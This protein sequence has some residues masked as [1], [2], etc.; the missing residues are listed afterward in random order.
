MLSALV[1]TVVFVLPLGLDVLSVST[2]LGTLGLIGRARWRVSQVLAGCQVGAMLVGLLLGAVLA[3]AIGKPAGYVG[4][5]VFIVLGGY[6]LLNQDTSEV[7]RVC[8]RMS[9]DVFGLIGSAS[10][11]ALTSLRPGS[12][13]GWPRFP[14]PLAASPSPSR[15]WLLLSSGYLWG[16]GSVHDSARQRGG[17]PPLASFLSVSTS[18]S[19]NLAAERQTEYQP[20]AVLVPANVVVLDIAAVARGTTMPCR[21]R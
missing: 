17:L 15:V 10:R 9:E 11:S 4:A 19:S 12:V 14:L 18:S 3:E 7:E 13:S 2:A 5:G 6:L 20:P 16:R 21:P 8:K 1:K